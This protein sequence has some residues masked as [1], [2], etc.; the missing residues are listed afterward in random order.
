MRLRLVPGMIAR[1]RAVSLRLPGQSLRAHRDYQARL[2]TDAVMTAIAVQEPFADEFLEGLLPLL[3]HEAAVGLWQLVVAA[4]STVAENAIRDAA[5]EALGAEESAD[6]RRLLLVAEALDEEVAWH[7]PARFQVA[8]NIAR[9]MLSGA[10]ARANEQL[11]YE[12]RAEWDAIRQNLRTDGT[13]RARYLQGASGYNWSGRGGSAAWRAERRVELQDFEE[14]L[15]GRSRLDSVERVVKPPGW[16]ARVPGNWCAYVCPAATTGMPEPYATW[17]AAGRLLAFPAGLRQVAWPL[18]LSPADPGCAPVPSIEPL[19]AAAEGLRPDRVSGFIEAV[20]VDWSS[21][22][23]HPDFPV[24]LYLPAHKAFELGFIDADERRLAM[25]EARAATL[26]EMADVIS[27]L[28]DD[29]RHYRAELEQAMGNARLFSR[30]VDGLG[31]EFRVV[32]ATW[33]WPGRSVVDEI[34]AGTSAKAVQWLA[35]WA[36]QTCTWMLQQSMEQAWRRAFDRNSAAYWLPAP[37][38]TPTII[39]ALHVSLRCPLKWMQA[40][41]SDCC[42]TRRLRSTPTDRTATMMKTDDSSAVTPRSWRSVVASVTALATPVGVGVLHPALGDIVAIVELVVA[43]T[44][45]VTALF[46]SPDLSDRTFR[47]LRWV[48]N[49]P[50]PPAPERA[51]QARA[52]SARRPTS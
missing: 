20:L 2:L 14:W 25:A 46:G 22:Q 49:R 3:R 45:I 1:A 26:R 4:T 50:E 12:Q 30:L 7:S 19:L 24:H 42:R 6:R 48:G 18:I 34:R 11:L 35:S 9:D 36:H 16:R 5:R 33:R 44:I 23:D 51:V 41:R 13:A 37:S 21:K 47:L 31:I 39:Q 17:V 10:N 43:L 40:R 32:K 15:I 29:Q 8:A 52:G 27:A 28:P 38:V